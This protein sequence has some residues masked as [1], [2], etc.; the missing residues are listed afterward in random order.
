MFCT[1]P[2]RIPL[3]GRVDVCCFDK[4]RASRGEEETYIRGAAYCVLRTVYCVLRT[5]YCVLCT[6]YCVLCT[7]YGVLLLTQILCCF[8][9]TGTLTSDDLEA[10]GV[11]LPPPRDGDGDGDGDGGGDGEWTLTE[12]DELP[13]ESTFVL[14][15]CQSLVQLPGAAGLAGDPLEMAAMEAIGWSQT[16]GDV[17]A[18]LKGGSPAGAKLRRLR[19]FDFSSA[20][21]RMSVIVEAE[22][23]G[24]GGKDGIPDRSILVLAKGA[25]EAIQD[26]LDPRTAPRDYRT[27]YLE[28]AARGYVRDYL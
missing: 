12:A 24:K 26:M 14:A 17:I 25:P 21:R 3:A 16:K 7:V 13:A 8:D 20:L 23:G 1:E 15:G 5:A 28:W 2:F 22:T 19:R 11:V 10:R 9:K 6:V 18:P 4:V 27:A